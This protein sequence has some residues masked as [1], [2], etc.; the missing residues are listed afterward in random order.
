MARLRTLDLPR[1]EKLHSVTE[2]HGQII[3]RIE[4]GDRQRAVDAMRKH[5]S[6][7][8]GRIDEIMEAHRDFFA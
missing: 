6:G 7:T 2:W 1:T 5:L 4:A 8:I 3:D